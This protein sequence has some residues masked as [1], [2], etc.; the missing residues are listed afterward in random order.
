MFFVIDWTWATKMRRDSR[1]TAFIL[2]FERLFNSSPVDDE[3][4][5]QVKEKDK[6][7]AQQIF[8]AYQNNAEKV[9]DMLQ[10][11]LIG[12]SLDRVHKIDLALLYEAIAEI[13]FL[14][15]PPAVVINEVLEIA[16]KY[17]TAESPKFINGVLSK[18]VNA[19]DGGHA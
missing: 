12:Y 17:S 15:S 9:A 5:Q 1:I 4:W 14:N 3:I 8:D 13:K 7:F 11:V 18:I 16:K 19:K 2:I 10:K 6:E